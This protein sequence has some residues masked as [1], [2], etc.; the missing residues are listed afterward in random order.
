MELDAKRIAV[1]FKAFCD[2]NR[3]KILQLLS[4]GEKC[5][6]KLLEEMQ[7]TQPTLSHHMKILCDSGI[8]AGRKEGKWMYYSISKKG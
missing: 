4:D 2:E 7:I 8:V 5:A 6:C 3:I 1:I